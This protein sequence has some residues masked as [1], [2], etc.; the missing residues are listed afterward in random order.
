M[1][2][3]LI[4]M[5]ASGKTTIGKKLYEK[6]KDNSSKKWIFLDGD[7]FRNILG[8]D[9]GH[10]IEDRRKNAYRISRF[11]EFLSSQGINVLACVLSIFHDNQ[12]YNKEIISNYKEV[13]IDVS[14]ENLVKRDN[15]Q[16]YKKALNGEI[17]DVV[18]V[19]IEFKPP[20]SPDLI[21]DNNKDNPNYEQMIK[22]ILVNFDIKTNTN[23]SYTQNN[24]LENP[25]KYQYSKFE[26]KEFFDKLIYDRNQSKNYLE[27]RL[28]KLNNSLIKKE[29]LKY[30]SF[31][32]ENNLI[33]KDFLIFLYQ[34]SKEELLKY[35]NTI[36]I[37]IK[38]FEVGKKLYLT[39]DLNEIRKSSVSFDELLNYPLFSLVLQKYYNYS[40]NQKKFVY[41]NA[42]LKVN[43]I[44]SSIK[45]EFILYDEVYYSIEAIS[46]ELQIIGE[47]I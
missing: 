1:V 14:F 10:T 3:W 45:S 38:R 43:D 2:I 11:C 17:K 4:G 46:N 18:G 30:N 13:Y 24:L 16:L 28:K 9:L 36:D 7:T 41:L 5:S 39:Y 27:N 31:E 19:D 25:H 37:L 33:L 47:N 12:K 26:G 22:N 23:Y 42:I 20:Y 35:S 8:E 21:I 6:L 44:I 40:N 32:L 15:K 34:S 29:N